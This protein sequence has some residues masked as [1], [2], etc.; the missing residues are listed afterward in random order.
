M[1]RQ[2]VDVWRHVVEAI[3][4]VVLVPTARAALTDIL[5]ATAIVLC[6]I[7]VQTLPR[8]VDA[9]VIEDEDLR[10]GRVDDHLLALDLRVVLESE[11]GAGVGQFDRDGARQALR[12]CALNLRVF[13]H[14]GKVCLVNLVVGQADC[15]FLDCAN[16]VL[17]V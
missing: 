14:Q 4:R 17:R 9:R 16:A 10:L 5:G 7:C 15:F 1:L 11:A 3:S 8:N 13:K 6:A 12:G 2:F